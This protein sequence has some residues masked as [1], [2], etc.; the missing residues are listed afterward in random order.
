MCSTGWG[1]QGHSC[2][3]ISWFISLLQL[4]CMGR[5]FF[6][7]GCY[8]QPERQAVCISGYM[9]LG[10][11]WGNEMALFV[12]YLPS[13]FAEACLCIHLVISPILPW[14][15]N[16][17]K[18]WEGACWSPSVIVIDIFSTTTW[19]QRMI[20]SSFFCFAH[21]LLS[22]CWHTMSTSSWICYWQIQETKQRNLLFCFPSDFSISPQLYP[23]LCL[24]SSTRWR[25]CV[26]YVTS[27]L[28]ICMWAGTNP[29]TMAPLL[30]EPCSTPSSAI[31]MQLKSLSCSFMVSIKRFISIHAFGAETPHGLW[32]R[33]TQATWRYSRI[34]V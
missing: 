8:L 6:C 16:W 27:T 2:P 5:L 33:A 28:T 13:P 31:S 23:S 29:L 34:F 20:S 10:C 26:P 25:W 22:F 24:Q 12:M 30:V 1:L 17:Q 15:I 14:C 21:L 9:S 11:V 4:A 19:K 32:R 3:I 18:E 7:V